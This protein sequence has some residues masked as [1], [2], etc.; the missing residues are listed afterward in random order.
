ML[1][2]A[3]D[4]K[5]LLLPE[6]ALAKHKRQHKFSDVQ[7]LAM[8]RRPS[9]NRRLYPSG[10]LICIQQRERKERSEREVHLDATTWSLAAFIGPSVQRSK[11][12]AGSRATLARRRFRAIGR[13]SIQS[14]HFGSANDGRS[15][16]P[17]KGRTASATAT[18][19]ND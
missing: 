12:Q 16:A 5:R 13:P 15:G 2:E 8:A 1:R 18:S 14:S 4:R 11:R 19:P 9:D 7:K 3:R 10:K 17:R 6:H